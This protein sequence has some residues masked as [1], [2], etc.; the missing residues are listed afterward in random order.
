MSEAFKTPGKRA[1]NLE[2]LPPKRQ[3]T[4][5][6]SPASDY[7][8]PKLSL[9]E[10][11]GIGAPHIFVW[12]LQS[13][14]LAGFGLHTNDILILNRKSELSDGRVAIVVVEGRH[15]ICMAQGRP[16]A[17]KLFIVDSHGRRLEME[18]SETVEL[19]GIVDFI[20]RDI[21]SI[22]I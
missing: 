22:V 13:D 8:C 15:R 5:F 7:E 16:G 3:V 1:E 9:D 6:A 14:A 2:N 17:F 12:R 20:F 10:M 11:T 21:R 18:Q 4:G 19:W